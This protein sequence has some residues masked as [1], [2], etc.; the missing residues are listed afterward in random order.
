MSVGKSRIHS[1]FSWTVI[2]FWW[3]MN[4]FL[5]GHCSL[6]R[7]VHFDFFLLSLFFKALIFVWN[8]H[9]VIFLD[10]QPAYYKIYWVLNI[11][12]FASDM[13]SQLNE[14]YIVSN[15]SWASKSCPVFWWEY[16]LLLYDKLC[17]TMR[18]ILNRRP[19]LQGS[20]EMPI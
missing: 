19:W 8:L 1:H 11:N 20:S 15:F 16:S 12:S 9:A 18:C 3:C 14:D 17:C 6:V 7:L 2:K 13:A 10:I 4:Y 5:L